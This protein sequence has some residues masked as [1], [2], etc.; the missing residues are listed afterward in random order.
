M[1][2][3]DASICHYNDFFTQ[4]QPYFRDINTSRIIVGVMLISCFKCVTSKFL[5]YKKGG[6]SLDC[7]PLL[8][9]GT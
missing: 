7:P 2:F 5:E 1:V 6:Q 3:F 8:E 9:Q 4:L